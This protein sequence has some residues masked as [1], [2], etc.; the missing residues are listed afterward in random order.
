[1]LPDRL[2]STAAL[3]KKRTQ[4]LCNTR[5]LHVEIMSAHIE[6]A[7]EGITHLSDVTN[8]C[9]LHSENMQMQPPSCNNSA[10]KNF[11]HIEHYESSKSQITRWIWK[12]SIDENLFSGVVNLS[13]VINYRPQWSW[14]LCSV[15]SLFYLVLP[16]C[17]RFIIWVTWDNLHVQ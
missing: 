10:Y 12:W 3:L 6:D 17:D 9:W 15:D 4:V 2:P 16:S 5:T 11:Q 7:K 1:M 13:D 8:D 14:C